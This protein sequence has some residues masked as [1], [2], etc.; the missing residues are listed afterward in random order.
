MRFD[1]TR[2]IETLEQ[3]SEY[4]LQRTTVEPRT[5]AFL[6]E[7]FERAGWRVEQLE[8]SCR[9]VRA[10]FSSLA[11]HRFLLGAARDPHDAAAWK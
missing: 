4:R 10:F 5:A 3:L 1:S 2:A 6:A 11:G 9:G 8:L 7:G